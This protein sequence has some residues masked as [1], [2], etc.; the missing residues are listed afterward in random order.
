MRGRDV[1]IWLSTAAVGALVAW[2]LLAGR[3][4]S[5]VPV[6]PP[7]SAEASPPAPGGDALPPRTG[8]EIPFEATERDWEIVQET[9]RRI[10]DQGP[11]DRP[12]GDL[13]VAVG[14]S[15]VGTPYEPGTLE[16][17]GPERLAVN[18]RTLDCV[19]F[20]ENA[21]VL[22][23]LVRTASDALVD[24]RDTLARAYRERLALL[25]YR[26]GLPEGY[27]S[28][29]HYFSEWLSRNDERGVIRLVTPGLSGAREDT[30]PLTF[31]SDHPD[32]YRQVAEDPAVLES[33]RALELGLTAPR[34]Y[35]PQD[36][37]EQAA[38]GGNDPG[39]VGIRNGDI[40][41]A[42]SILDGLDVAHTG[43]AVWEG[44]ELHLLH[45]PLVGDS[46]EVSPRPLGERLRGI[47]AQ[48]GIL[49]AR[50]VEP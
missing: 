38:A 36:Q 30:R 45:A 50:P 21:L 5:L 4:S 17:P 19:T 33:I 12:M 42:K 34:W 7:R 32:A 39:E 29:L 26:E 9:V 11:T 28:R 25:R 16:L 46:V 27:A 47:R 2:G 31:M 37:V 15:F 44:G 40:I 20:V 35:I 22:A 18:L 10:R 43:I 24:D 23:H 48:D 41:A 14:L 8:P 6:D 1:T 13:V 49:V 3:V